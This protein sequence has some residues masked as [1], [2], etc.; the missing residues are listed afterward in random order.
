MKS[1]HS[2]SY[3]FMSKVFNWAYRKADL[4]ITIGRDMDEVVRNKLGKKVRENSTT[5]IENW[6][7]LD[8]IF[9]KYTR[10]Q[11]GMV[12]IQFAG[13]V[14]RVQG[15]PDFLKLYEESNNQSISLDVW[16]DGA[17]RKDLQKYV[18][19][20]KIDNVTFHGAYKRGDQNE[21]LNSCDIA[22]VSLSKGMYGLGVPSKSYNI[23]AAGK[24]I[25]FIGD[26]NS[27]IALEIKEHDMGYAFSA[28][29]ENL[30]VD[31][32]KHLDVN[33][34]ED[35]MKKGENARRTVVEL[36][37]EKAILDKFYN[38]LS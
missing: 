2:L 22:L 35:F 20:N 6:A 33:M 23:M 32:L 14:G 38:I 28:E 24:P 12:R 21:V 37:S 7:D 5:I 19:E 31:W 10:V 15:L 17:M 29:E 13:N 36:Y 26:L 1:N 8:I 4:L 27:E 9:P 25:L 16:G 11:D 18:E 34:L 3:R 30:I